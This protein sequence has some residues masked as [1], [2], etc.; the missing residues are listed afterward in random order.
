MAGPFKSRPASLSREARV[1]LAP[2]G[3]LHHDPLGAVSHGFCAFPVDCAF[4]NGKTS[5]GRHSAARSAIPSDD[6]MNRPPGEATDV[7]LQF[8]PFGFERMMLFALEDDRLSVSGKLQ[9]KN[10]L[11]PEESCGCSAARSDG[12][13]W[14]PP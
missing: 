6:R 4:G 13:R 1:H 8:A 14:R 7:L 3:H 5:S 9:P 11:L 12:A 10:R 2:H